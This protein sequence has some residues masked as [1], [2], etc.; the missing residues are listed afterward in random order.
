VGIGLD[1]LNKRL[2]RTTSAAA[3]NGLGAMINFLR[4]SASIGLGTKI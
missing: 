2:R 3:C 1:T 4:G